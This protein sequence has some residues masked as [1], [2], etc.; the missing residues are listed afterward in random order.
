MAHRPI[1]FTLRGFLAQRLSA[2][3]Q[4]IRS[5]K[6]TRLSETVSTPFAAQVMGKVATS[7]RQTITIARCTVNK[8]LAV[9]I[10]LLSKQCPAI[11][12][13]RIRRTV[14]MVGLYSRL[15][16]DG[17]AARRLCGTLMTRANRDRRRAYM[18]L[19]AVIFSWDKEKITDEE[20][21]Q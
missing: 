13:Q 14:Q 19:G 11:I 17:S 21:D 2:P 15:G 7:W 6:L 9:L 8:Q 18:L 5:G 10:S 4:K 20:I 12:A 16:Y 3:L 1:V